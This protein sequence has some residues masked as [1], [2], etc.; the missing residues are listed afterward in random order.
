MEILLAI[1]CVLS[2]SMNVILLKR[3]NQKEFTSQVFSDDEVGQIKQVLNIL[4]WGGED[5]NKN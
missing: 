3:V 2:V 4:M 5:E 1:I